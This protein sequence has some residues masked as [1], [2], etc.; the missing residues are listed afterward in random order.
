MKWLQT[1]LFGH[2]ETWHTCQYTTSP[3][4]IKL[5]AS[6]QLAQVELNCLAQENNAINLGLIT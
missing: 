2:E 5:Y 6:T 1:N 4:L 3:S